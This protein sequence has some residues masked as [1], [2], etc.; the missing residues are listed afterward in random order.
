VAQKSKPKARPP[1]ACE[2]TAERVVAARAARSHEAI[3]AVAG[4]SLPAG[5]VSPNLMNTN[6]P[7]ALELRDAISDAL[8]RVRAGSHDVAVVLPDSAVRVV[9]LDFETLPDRDQDAAPLIRFRLKR[10][11]PFDVERAAVS[12]QRQRTNGAVQVLAA[13][14]QSSVIEEYEQAFRAAG[15]NPGIVLPSILAA[16][17]PVEEGAP[18]LVVKVERGI[19]SLAIVDH[20]ELRLVRTIEDANTTTITGERLAEDIYASLVFFQDT[21]GTSVD[22]VLL[23]GSIDVERMREPLQQA[24][25]VRVADVVGPEHMAPSISGDSLPRAALAGVVGALL[26]K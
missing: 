4:R 14:A 20:G 1:L 22:R 10:V 11:L 18:T 21:Y 3:E 8:G 26:V 13:V 2:I 9:V 23:G 15:Y 6:V 16:L 17:G 19:L 25:G 24:V 5:A 12:Y 7:Q